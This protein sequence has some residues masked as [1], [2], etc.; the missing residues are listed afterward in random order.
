MSLPLLAHDTLTTALADWDQREG[1]TEF[2]WLVF[3]AILG[4]QGPLVVDLA[5][6]LTSDAFDRAKASYILT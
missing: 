3:A 1:L 6:F 2:A 5:Q 4:S